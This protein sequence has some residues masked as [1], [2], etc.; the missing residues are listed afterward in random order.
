[1]WDS[2]S[3]WIQLFMNTFGGSYLHEAVSLPIKWSNKSRKSNLRFTAPLTKS[4]LVW[5]QTSVRAEMVPPFWILYDRMK[6]LFNPFLLCYLQLFLLIRKNVSR[7]GR[8]SPCTHTA[9]VVGKSPPQSSR[10][11]FLFLN[12][13]LLMFGVKYSFLCPVLTWISHQM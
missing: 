2:V 8:F 9:C 4:L 10:L 5:F 6:M 12:Y 11:F 1:M 13:L 3:I 7:W